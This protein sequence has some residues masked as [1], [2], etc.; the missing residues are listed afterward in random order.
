MKRLIWVLFVCVA[1]CCLLIPQASAAGKPDKL[2]IGVL[3]DIS[4][5]YAPVVGSFRP[6]Y[7]DACKYINEEMGGIKGVPVEPL[8]RDNGGKVAVSLAQYNELIN[9]KPRPVFIDTAF[10]PVAEALRPRYVEDDMI[11]IHAGNIVAVYPLANSYAY[12]PMYDEWFGVSAKWFKNNW[13]EKRNPR[14]GIITWDTAYGRGM[15]TEKF[16]DYLKEIGVDLAGKPQ[17]FGIRDVDVTTQLMKLKMW[18]S[19]IVFSCITAGGVLAVKKGM[20]EMGWDVPYVANGLD[21]GTLNLDPVV[22]DGVYVQRALLSW[23]ETDHPAMKFILKQFKKNNRTK[24]DMSAFYLLAW[25][26]MAVE[27]KVITEV[28]EKYGWDGLTTQNLK[29]A[30]NRVK[31]F[32]PWKGLTKLTYTAKRP[33]PVDMRM[34]QAQ[35]GKLLP[36][37]EW[38]EAPDFLPTK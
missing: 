25:N 18:K 26:N 10:S 16:F 34:Y 21:L 15:L 33:V 38:E 17:L 11:G 27:R 8:I 37:T 29:A 35:K 6:G 22:L 36:V 28:V 1:A 12:Y 3:A 19:D 32:L 4:G 5:P 9:R 30:M 20:K 14:V 7:I 13:K 24:K 23:N 31:D 2:Y